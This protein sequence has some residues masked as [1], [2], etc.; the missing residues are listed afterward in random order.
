VGYREPEFEP[1][2]TTMR[3]GGPLTTALLVATG[4]A[5]QLDKERRD[6]KI[7]YTGE[8]EREAAEFES[9]LEQASKDRSSHVLL[10]IPP[11][12]QVTRAS[13]PLQVRDAF[14]CYRQ[15]NRNTNRAASPI[16]TST[17]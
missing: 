10:K 5:G 8:I 15:S 17:N 6:K 16:M 13:F 11:E 2:E 12:R 1:D 7:I 9:V 4:N 3:L 14:S